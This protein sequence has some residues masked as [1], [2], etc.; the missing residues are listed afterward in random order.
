MN[1][2]ESECG[3]R[4]R[5]GAQAHPPLAAGRTN[6]PLACLSL[7]G[8]R[9]MWHGKRDQKASDT[10]AMGSQGPSGLSGLALVRTGGS[11]QADGVPQLWDLG[12]ESCMDIISGRS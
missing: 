4:S 11:G 9:G 2:R 5:R 3:T 7:R 12:G 10:P 6:L 8:D 1:P